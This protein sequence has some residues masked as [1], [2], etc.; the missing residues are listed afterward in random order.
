MQPRA[1]FPYFAGAGQKK[2]GHFCKALW[3]PSWRL[4]GWSTRKANLGHEGVLITLL[5][6]GAVAPAGADHPDAG[7]GRR[8]TPGGRG[9]SSAGCVASHAW[10]RVARRAGLGNSADALASQRGFGGGAP[11]S[12][13]KTA[14]GCKAG[15]HRPPS[16]DRTRPLCTGH[17]YVQI[18]IVV[19]QILLVRRLGRCCDFST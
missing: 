14:Q 3:Y 2:A 13:T 7:N 9:C 1:R 5:S 10:R 12:Q 18:R 11:R 4:G 15:I 16:A 8:P 17:N 6:Y 19:A